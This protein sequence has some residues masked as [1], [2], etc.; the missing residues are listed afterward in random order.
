M[1]DWW[2]SKL[3]VT[4]RTNIICF[5]I[6]IV[7]SA[8]CIFIARKKKLPVW[9]LQIGWIFAMDFLSVFLLVTRLIHG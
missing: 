2:I 5:C 4:D 6:I 7:I 8:I 1:T 3:T 9:K